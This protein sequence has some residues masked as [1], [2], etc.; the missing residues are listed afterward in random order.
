[1]VPGAVWVAGQ[2]PVPWLRWLA[3]ILVAVVV[4]RIGYEPRIVGDDLGTTPVFNWLLYGYGVPAAAFWFAGW[5]LRQ[6]A[7]D[8]PAR[9][10]DSGAILFTVLLVVSEIRHYVTGGDLYAAS[11]GITEIALYANAGL[12]M[13]IGLERVRGRSGSPVHDI[14]ALIIAALTLVAIIVNLANA[15]GPSVF[16][17]PVSG[18]FVNLIMLDYGLPAILAFALALI[19]RTTRPLPYRIAAVIAAVALSLCYLT[20]EVRRLF[21]GPIL[22]GPVSDAEQYAYSSAWLAFGIVLL[23]V[24]FVLRSQPA[25]LVALGVIAVT[26]AKVFIIDTASIT[27]IYRAL[28]VIGLGI[29][30]LGVGWLYQRLLYPRTRLTVRPS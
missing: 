22:G 26:V 1:M 10:V 28:S 2:R 30:L 3:A 7:D 29:V 20:L 21:H 16:G 23:A 12:A 8:L 18:T 24:G 14:G 13:T 9:A 4:A 6:R 19:A 27:G 11:D 5:R 15:L 17:V 25:R